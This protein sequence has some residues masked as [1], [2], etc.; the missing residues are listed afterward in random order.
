MK[1]KVWV[2]KSIIEDINHNVNVEARYNKI[3]NVDIDDDIYIID[4]RDTPSEFSKAAL[5]L[6]VDGQFGLINTNP[7]DRLE[8]SYSR[9]SIKNSRFYSH[10]MSSFCIRVITGDVCLGVETNKFLVDL[11]EGK[12]RPLLSRSLV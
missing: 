6:N 8:S 11:K 2:L 10:L 7:Q 12:V 4:C 5:K 1:P 9:Y 3:E